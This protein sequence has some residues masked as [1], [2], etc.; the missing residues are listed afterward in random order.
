MKR[1]VAGITAA[2]L[3]CLFTGTAAF[4]ASFKVITNNA[5]PS[6]TVSKGELKNLYLGKTSRW[7]DGAKADPVDLPSDS[8]AREAFSEEVLGKPVS[9][10]KSNW[11]RLIFSGKGVPPPEVSGDREAVSFVKGRSGAVGYVSDGAATEGVKVLTV[12][13]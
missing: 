6:S 12:T 2:G 3:L 10:V 1:V 5:F 4:G 13:D 9:A 8:E 11:Q 7:R